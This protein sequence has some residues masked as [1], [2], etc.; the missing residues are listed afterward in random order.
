MQSL[1]LVI[2]D[3]ERKACTHS[4]AGPFS[5]WQPASVCSGFADRCREEQHTPLGGLI[6]LHSSFRMLWLLPARER[7]EEFSV[8]LGLHVQ[9]W[10][11]APL[12]FIKMPAYSVTFS[13]KT[14]KPSGILLSSGWS[15]GPQMC[16][17]SPLWSA[18]HLHPGLP[19]GC[20]LLF[21]PCPPSPEQPSSELSP[22]LRHFQVA[23]PSLQMWV[24]WS[25]WGKL[26]L[27]RLPALPQP[28]HSDCLPRARV[29]SA[30]SIE[31]VLSK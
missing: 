2:Q 6:W 16:F 20:S 27:A 8:F 11:L 4:S 17:G 31:L 24:G 7:R 1:L 21:L 13:F 28:P 23:P 30:P 3:W 12:Q 19:R 5:V 10:T 29:A 9:Y 14:S 18:S 25:S 15:P 26:L 22:E